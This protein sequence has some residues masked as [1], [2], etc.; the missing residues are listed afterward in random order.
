MFKPLL[1][2]LPSL[3]GNIKL[4]CE[5]NDY[6]D[7]GNNVYSTYIS[8]ASLQPLQNNPCFHKHNPLVM[9]SHC[10]HF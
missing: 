8:S 4:A 2:T 5:I 10:Q 7:E 3:T 1:R 9:L 6:V